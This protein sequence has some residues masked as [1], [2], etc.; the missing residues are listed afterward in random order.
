MRKIGV[1]VL[2]LLFLPTQAF[3]EDRQFEDREHVQIQPDK[4]YILVRTNTVRE[5]A[6][7]GT[8]MVSP[9]LYRALGDMELQQ[10][11]DKAKSD[12]DH[13]KDGMPPNVVVV[14]GD[15]P[16]DQLPDVRV[17]LIEVQPGSY[18]LG[19]AAVTNWATTHRGIMATS[20]CMGTVKFEAKAGMITDMGTILSAP[21]QSPTSIPELANVVTDTDSGLNRVNE[22]AL[23]PANSSTEI[24]ASLADQPRAAADYRAMGAF[25]NYA[26]APLARLT[27]VPGVLDYDKDGNVVDLQAAKQ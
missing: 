5:G 14:L 12:P 23:R 18:I 13:W 1:I 19:G 4:A 8:V 3:C 10:A 11:A 6:L 16:Y 24:P 20:L 2:A 26:G 27:P 7:K 25:P 15:T 9:V 17:L 22:L 21:D